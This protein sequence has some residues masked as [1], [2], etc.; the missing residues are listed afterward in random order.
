MLR[1]VYFHHSSPISP[2]IEHPE[3]SPS[4]PCTKNDINPRMKVP[5]PEKR[6][7]HDA[8]KQKGSLFPD[9]L[10]AIAFFWLLLFNHFNLEETERIHGGNE[11]LQRER[12]IVGDDI[13]SSHIDK[14][15]IRVREFGLAVNLVF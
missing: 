13:G 15:P 7:R 11:P 2:F 1:I 14:R 6:H 4:V 8:Y 5:A 12:G 10:S 3:A 9:S